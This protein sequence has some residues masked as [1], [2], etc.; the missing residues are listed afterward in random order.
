MHR[1]YCSPVAWRDRSRCLFF[2]SSERGLTDDEVL[3]RA[4]AADRILI[5]NDKDFGD[6]IFR[7]RQ[8]HRGVI[9]LRL[10]DERPVNKIRVLETLLGQHADQVLGN[11]IVAT[12]TSV[13]VVRT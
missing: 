10:S 1:A 3:L 9:L 8:R 6:M 7:Q 13:R 12:D 11:F 2:R 5:T 4:V